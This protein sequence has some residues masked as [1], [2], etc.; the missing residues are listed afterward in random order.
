MELCK[1]HLE[2]FKH[3][4][5]D[6]KRSTADL[7]L[8]TLELLIALERDTG[9]IGR[10]LLRQTEQDAMFTEHSFVFKMGNAESIRI[11]K[12]FN[13]HITPLNRNYRQLPAR[14]I[15]QAFACN[16]NRNGEKN[17]IVFWTIQITRQAEEQ[18]SR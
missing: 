9:A 8:S 15:I 10:G 17:G 5:G 12:V 6:L 1:I 7:P 11:T 4:T 16:V 18:Y 3:L 14:T 2:C 13:I